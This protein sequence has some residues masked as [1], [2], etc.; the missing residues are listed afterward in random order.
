[1]NA[2]F[3]AFRAAPRAP[4]HRRR[5]DPATMASSSQWCRP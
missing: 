3:L 1:M 4:G 5:A 2:L